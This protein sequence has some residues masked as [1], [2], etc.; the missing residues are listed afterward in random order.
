VAREAWRNVLTG[1][2]R[3]G[4]WTLLATA[5]WAAGGWLEAR[6]TAGMVEESTAYVAGGGA[7]WV[8]GAD[9][10]ISGPACDALGD[11][12]GIH[13]AGALR[14][15]QDQ[16]TLAVLPSAPL[17]VYEVTPGLMR[18]FALPPTVGVGLPAAAADRLGLTPPAEVI[19]RSGP[20]RVAGVYDYPDDGR[21][22]GLGY[23]VL[24]PV[25]STKAF[26][27]C[28]FQVWP[29]DER[30]KAL[31]WTALLPGVQDLA[32]QPPQLSQLNPTFQASF[33]GAAA[34]TRRATRWAP[35]ATLSAGLILGAASVWAR[36]LEVAADLHAGLGRAA[37]TARLSGESLV[38]VALAVPLAVS[39]VIGAVWGVTWAAW[40]VVATGL[41]AVGSGA[42]GALAGALLAV[43]AIRERQL[44][45]YFKSR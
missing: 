30:A 10:A 15:R 1:A 25:V 40:G 36:R 26:D 39:V 20:V 16:L 9:A 19:T 2:A 13:G 34:F 12:P 21:R 31:A 44:F 41:R 28:W 32:G 7:T 18:L 42:F 17:P 33:D 27:E 22:G 6:Q 35:A 45:A 14:Q 11:A 5:V 4:R 43:C 23:A 37:L 3:T 38:W 29:T 8:L 24:S